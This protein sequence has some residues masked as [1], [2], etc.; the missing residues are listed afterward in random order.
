MVYHLDIIYFLAGAIGGLLIGLIGAGIG[1]IIVPTMI[2]CLSGIGIA[3]VIAM[4]I[5]ICTSLTTILVTSLFSMLLHYKNKSINWPLFYRLLPGSVVGAIIG[6]GVIIIFASQTL[7]IIFSIFLL[8]L[9][10]QMIINFKPCAKKIWPTY[11]VAFSISGIIAFFSNVIGI[12]DGM[13]TIPFLKRYHVTMVEAIATATALIIPVSSVGATSLFI[14]GIFDPNLPALC[15][16]YIY[17]PAFIAILL[18]SLIFSRIGIRL[19]KFVPETFLRN[20]FAISVICAS[21]TMLAKSNH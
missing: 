12:S 17:I 3:G 6:I 2:F 10:L 20:L 7:K 18:G 11:P 9:G 15:F 16:G 21:I 19:A 14:K 13:F 1:A 5:A 4:H 8:L